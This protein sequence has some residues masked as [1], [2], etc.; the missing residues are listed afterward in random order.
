MLMLSS[1]QSGV[2]TL[3]L[4]DSCQ[5]SPGR[6]PPH[7][8]WPASGCTS[9]AGCSHRS[10]FPAETA[11]STRPAWCTYHTASPLNENASASCGMACYTLIASCASAECQQMP[12]GCM[13]RCAQTSVPLVDLTCG[14]QQGGLR[15]PH[16]SLPGV[17]C[18]LCSGW[19]PSPRLCCHIQQHLWY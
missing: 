11:G 18:H 16:S 14:V 4:R 13:A 7:V 1:S 19:P 5:G 15:C 2:C 3:L 17:V 12:L 6:A 10:G 8:S 9:S